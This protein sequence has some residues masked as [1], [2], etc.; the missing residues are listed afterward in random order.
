M[1][2]ILTEEEK[3]VIIYN[4][5]VLK[6][7][8]ATAGKS[9]GYNQYSVEK[10]LKE[11]GIQK[12]TYV[13]AK[14][15]LRKYTI[16]DNFFK[17][18]NT[19]M[20]Y[21]LG[22]LASDGSIAKKENGIFLELHQQDEEIL[23]KIKTKTNSSR[24]LSHRINNNQTPCVKFQVWSA[25]WKED[26]AKYGIKPNKTF[27]LEPPTLLEPKYRI[28]YI[29]GYFDGDGCV[30]YREPKEGSSC[31]NI[32]GASKEVI[33]WIRNE[34]NNLGISTSSF[35]HKILNN[36]SNYYELI[37]YRKQIL[38]MIY[39]SFYYD[40]NILYLKRKKQKFEKIINSL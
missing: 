34:L 23:E 4:Y 11:R 13:E 31:V 22:L 35:N 6:Q 29:R 10:L 16:N 26:L 28:D 18:Q 2:R 17:T 7:G 36:N 33:K 27:S 32:G 12:R 3:D 40:N 38:Q 5:C 14:Q 37:Y 25:A 30:Y 9:F 21:L 8:L 24:E 20:A 39:N 1:S 15:A 19:D